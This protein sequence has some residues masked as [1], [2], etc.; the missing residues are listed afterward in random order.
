VNYKH[1]E[2]GMDSSAFNL[3]DKQEDIKARAKA[4]GEKW[5]SFAKEMDV[6]NSAPIEKMLKDSGE[7]PMVTFTSR[8]VR[9][10]K[11]IYW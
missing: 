3:T 8:T 6:N 5:A 7:V 11:K 1:K 4:F 10:P 9:F 2:A